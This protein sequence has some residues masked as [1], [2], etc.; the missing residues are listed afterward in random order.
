MVLSARGIAVVTSAAILAALSGSPRIDA[1]PERERILSIHNI[2]NKETLSIIYKRDGEYVPEALKKLNWVM[3]DWRRN[4]PTEMDPKLLDI[5]WEVHTELGSRKPIHLISGYRSRKTNNM[6]RKTRGGQARKSQHI[7]G[8]AADVHFP[9]VP[10]KRLRYSALVRERGGVGYYPTSALPFVH[11]D[12]GR[13]RHWPRMGRQELALLFPNGR[14]KHRPRGGGPITKRDAA[15]ARKANPALA[16]KVAAFHGLRSGPHQQ[17]G[18]MLASVEPG[19]IDKPAKPTFRV[20]LPKLASLGTPRDLLSVLP[21]TGRDSTALVQRPRVVQRHRRSGLRGPTDADLARAPS[22]VQKGPDAIASL[23]ATQDRASGKKSRAYAFKVP[24]AR[25]A[26][27]PALPLDEIAL[28]GMNSRRAASRRRVAALT[29]Q[30]A[31]AEL[32]ES[33][34]E[35]S[36][37]NA[38]TNASV[39]P[40]PSAGT[41]TI[42]DEPTDQ[43]GVNGFV[44]SISRAIQEFTGWASAPE[45]D[46]E[47]PS[48]LS[49]R[50]FPI[51]PLLSATPSIDDPVLAR[52][53]HPDQYGA[54]DLIGQDQD[55]LPLSFK[56]GLQVAG[57]IWS[58]KFLRGD[59]ASIL[60]AG[61]S[62]ERRRMAGATRTN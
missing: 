54:R 21:G 7:L 59:G 15:R 55:M 37:W 34:A 18:I 53:V 2:H 61:V 11:I 48:E 35:P 17:A 4:E 9:D 56:P 36:F 33:D 41:D 60:L 19:L 3:R 32:F 43:S 12:T 44:D 16:Q 8:K 52:L 24:K 29:P 10:V 42:T 20:P 57:L 38:N 49:Y 23:L 6:L 13:V 51:G 28:P 50:P 5:L 26:E 30:V 25:L 22:T 14:S 1:G 39:S 45:Y 47:H 31:P 46:Q 40:S 58:D 62:E 27:R